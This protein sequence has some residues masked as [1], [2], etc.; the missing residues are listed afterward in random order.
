MWTSINNVFERHTLL[1]KLAAR[2]R[3][4]TA[5]L[6]A[7]ESILKF[8]NRIRQLAASLKSMNVD[9]PEEEM[10]MALLNG[11]PDDYK[12]L[13]SAIDAADDS[14][15][16]RWDFVK[17]RIMQEEQRID[18]RIKSAQEK[19]ET[20]AFLGKK[21]QNPTCSNCLAATPPPQPHPKC[22]H[23]NM[24]VHTEEKCWKK[25]PH[26]RPRRSGFKP[27]LVAT[28][29]K[30]DPTICLLASR[31]K[32]TKA[33]SPSAS[34]M[35]ISFPDYFNPESSLSTPKPDKIKHYCCMAN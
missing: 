24:R 11:L 34:R 31:S 5:S 25:C 13:I 9:I 1:N 22:K 18:M 4:Y 8:S 17:S 6:Q 28:P 32:K 10:A 16:L 21:S 35:N 3:F 33:T 29:G 2:K 19:S 26:F 12:A 30:D 20:A 23:C 27:S 15:Q 7:N 14:T